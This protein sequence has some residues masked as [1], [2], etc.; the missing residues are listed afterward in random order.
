MHKL[1]GRRVLDAVGSIFVVIVR[2]LRRW[3]VFGV[4]RIDGVHE[5]RGGVAA[6]EH[7]RDGL[8]QLHRRLL[9][10]RARRLAVHAV[11]RGAL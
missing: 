6:G 7:G 3:Y 2:E 5:L 10:A 9:R 8:H 4:C 1:L 11:L